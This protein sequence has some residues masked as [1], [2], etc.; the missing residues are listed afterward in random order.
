MLK[1][2]MRA[3]V[4]GLALAIL[5]V[6]G[7][8]TQEI[9]RANTPPDSATLAASLSDETGTGVLVFANS[10]V[11]VDD[12]DVAAAG[13]RLLGAAGTLTFTGLGAGFDENLILD[14]DTTTNLI[15][16]SSTSGAGEVEWNF[17]AFTQSA[18]VPAGDVI[19]SVGNESTDASANA[20]GVY[21]YTL[22]DDNIGDAYLTLRVHAT[23]ADQATTSITATG[24]SGSNPNMLF[25]GASSY[26]MDAKT[27]APAFVGTT[28]SPA[29]ANIGANSCGTTAATIAGVDNAF[30]ITVGATSG[31]ACRVTFDT[32][33]PNA[34][35]CSYSNQTTANLARQTAST[36]TTSDVSGTFVA[37]DVL[38]GVCIAR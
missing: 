25:E 24:A 23:G 1:A 3:F 11:F 37:G 6:V 7:A 10:P 2:T 15:K 26:V 22:G 14:L 33:A 9:R 5:L 30:K 8:E 27:T 31:T 19:Y 4:G 32:T 12:I 36:T 17:E 28:T 34:W 16:F 38:A 29:V 13:V 35:E 18:V 20:A 21:V